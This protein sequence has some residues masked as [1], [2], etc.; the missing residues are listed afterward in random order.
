MVF[1]SMKVNVIDSNKD[2]L[3]FVV[4]NGNTKL[5]VSFLNTHSTMNS[6]N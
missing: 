5:Y 2:Q 3:I 4:I 1:L 6:V